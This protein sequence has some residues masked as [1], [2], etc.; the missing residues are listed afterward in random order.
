MVLGQKRAFMPLYIEKINGDVDRQGEYRA[1]CLFRKL[2][3]RKKAAICNFYF[4]IQ[5]IV[6]ACYLNPVQ[7]TDSFCAENLSCRK[8]C[9]EGL[10]PCSERR[11]FYYSRYLRGTSRTSDR[12]FLSRRIFKTAYIWYFR[13]RISE[14]KCIWESNNMSV[15]MFGACKEISSSFEV[16]VRST[17]DISRPCCPRRQCKIFQLRGIFFQLNMCNMH[18][19]LGKLSKT[20]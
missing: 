1:I 5:V 16:L 14:R 18:I 15:N 6:S 11:F 12:V 19:V 4:I 20:F 9:S 3:N 8:K 2:E 17:A 13:S 10:F 7:M